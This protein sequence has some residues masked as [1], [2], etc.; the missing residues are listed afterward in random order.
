MKSS[1]VL[2]VED[3]G[4]CGWAYVDEVR[5]SQ[6]AEVDK[7]TKGWEPGEKCLKVVNVV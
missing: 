5:T 1:T 2:K 3:R 6:L 7:S 4:R